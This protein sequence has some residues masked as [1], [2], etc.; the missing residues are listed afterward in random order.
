MMCAPSCSWN[1]VHRN[2]LNKQASHK[3]NILLLHNKEN[4]LIRDCE[5]NIDVAD[6]PKTIKFDNHLSPKKLGLRI[7]NKTLVWAGIENDIPI[8]ASFLLELVAWLPYLAA[9]FCM[10][11]L[12]P[13]EKNKCPAISFWPATPSPWYLLMGA[14]AWGRIKIV[15]DRP[16]NAHRIYF[17]DV[18]QARDLLNVPHGA[19]NGRCVDIRKSH[20]ASVFATVFGYTLTCDPTQQHGLVVEKPETNGTHAGRVITTPHK[21]VKNY[22]YQKLIDTTDDKNLCNDLRTPCI[23]G[24]PV[25]VWRKRKQAS[26]RFAV[27]NQS[28]TLLNVNDVYSAHELDLIKQFN[29][30]IGLECGGLDILRDRNDGRIYIVDVNKT[31][32]GPLIALSWSD[33]MK[34]LKILGAA[35]RS[36]LIER[37]ASL[38]TLS[39]TQIAVS[40]ASE[41]CGSANFNS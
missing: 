12:T 18:T 24:M 9:F 7:K 23:G 31:D 29:I 27:Y 41:S 34:S 20:V 26:N 28:A 4:V 10:K 3:G 5:P 2:T 39:T 8:T 1:K 16:S 17:D 6:T 37:D 21:P 19:I 40:A 25:L 35:L 36:W 32:I 14:T 11:V 30:A 22:V 13:S 38:Q 33:K 15:K